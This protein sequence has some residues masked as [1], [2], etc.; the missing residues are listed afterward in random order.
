MIRLRIDPHSLE[1]APCFIASSTVA[2]EDLPLRGLPGKIDKLLE[3]EASRQIAMGNLSGDWES[4]ALLASRGRVGPKFVLFAGLGS[5]R[6]VTLSALSV[7]IEEIVQRV[8]KVSAQDLALDVFRSSSAE[9]EYENLASETVRGVLRGAAQFPYD[10]TVTICEPDAGRFIE[11]D[12]VAENTAFRHVEGR[13][14]SVE[15]I[16]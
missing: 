6:K 1:Q 4:Q 10:V 8:L 14:L 15:I 7:R 13:E 12:A 2:E 9:G 5:L 3:G 16:L 11:F